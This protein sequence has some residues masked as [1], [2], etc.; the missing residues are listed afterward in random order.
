MEKKIKF[1]TAL[2]ELERVIAKLESNDTPLDEAIKLYEKGVSLIRI[3][4]ERLD[5]AEQKIK[6]LQNSGNQVT[7]SEFNEELQ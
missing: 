6:L 1:E 2:A 5:G 3:C 7:E 4:S